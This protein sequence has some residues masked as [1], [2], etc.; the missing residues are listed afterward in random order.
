MMYLKPIGLILLIFAS[1]LLTQQKG[2]RGIV[3][4]HSTRKD[5]ERLVGTPKASR[6]TTYVMKDGRITVFYSDG[7]CKNDGTID[8]NVPPDTVVNLKFEPNHGLMIADLDMDMAKFERL[9]D[10][11][12]QIAVHYYSKEEGI[13]ISARLLRAG[14]EVQYII[15]EPASKDF[16]L[17]CPQPPRPE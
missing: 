9:N 12:A 7:V 16:H 13:R 14:E 4:L 8:W 3:P 11:H 6:A 10:P 5:V 15:Y 17:R 1:L 2:W